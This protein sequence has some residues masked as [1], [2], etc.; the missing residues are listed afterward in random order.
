L[1][2]LCYSPSEFAEATGLSLTLVYMGLR[3]G[4]IPARRYGRR[5]LIPKESA[6]AWLAT[7]SAT[8]N[9]DLAAAK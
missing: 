9:D 7:G 5:L 2:R 3:A 1:E 8:K 6:A 4:T